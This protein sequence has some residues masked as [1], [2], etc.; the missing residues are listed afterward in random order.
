MTSHTLSHDDMQRLLLGSE[1]LVVQMWKLEGRGGYLGK[2]V[3]GGAWTWLTEEQ[4]SRIRRYDGPSPG[5]GAQ[6]Q[7]HL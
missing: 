2:I 7:F 4:I 6:P 1:G 3:A 5:F